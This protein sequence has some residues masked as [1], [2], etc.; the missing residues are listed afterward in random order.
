MRARTWITGQKRLALG[1]LLILALFV[2]LFMST[3]YTCLLKLTPGSCNVPAGRACPW[4][5]MTSL[6]ASSS[7]DEY[8]VSE[9]V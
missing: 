5:G 6:L 9:W 8:G 7:I 4:S 1:I 3:L 2:A